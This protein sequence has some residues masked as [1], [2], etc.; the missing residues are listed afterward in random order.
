MK[1][2]ILGHGREGFL[3][4]RGRTELDALEDAGV[5]DVDTGVDAVSDKLD[6]L[7]NK[8]VDAGGVVGLVNNNTVL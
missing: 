7:L 1:L 6:G 4:D 5:Q 8:A 3:L 2:T